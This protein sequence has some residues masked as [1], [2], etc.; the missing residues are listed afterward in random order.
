[1]NLK[2]IMKV[3]T[4]KPIYYNSTETTEAVYHLGKPNSLSKYFMVYVTSKHLDIKDKPLAMVGDMQS[5][6]PIVEFYYSIGL[7]GIKA[8][9]QLIEDFKQEHRYL[10]DTLSKRGTPKV[11]FGAINYKWSNE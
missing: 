2:S 9:V 5:D 4:T 1:M 11:C 6:D 3:H 10:L 8:I 7:E